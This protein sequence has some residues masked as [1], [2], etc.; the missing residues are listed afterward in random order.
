HV[1]LHFYGASSAE[2]VEDLAAFDQVV[3]YSA[4]PAALARTRQ[5]LD[6]GLRPRPGGPRIGSKAGPPVM[7]SLSCPWV[8]SRPGSSSSKRLSSL[9]PTAYEHSFVEARPQGTPTR[10]NGLSN[11]ARAATSRI[12]SAASDRNCLWSSAFDA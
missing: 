6:E 10:L 4:R 11:L 9:I 1:E 3:L 12:P 7:A 8:N 2:R 5:I